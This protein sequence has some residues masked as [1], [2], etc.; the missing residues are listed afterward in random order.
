MTTTTV[1]LE[2]DTRSKAKPVVAHLPSDRDEHVA[3]CG[4][5]LTGRV[6]PKACDRCVVCQGLARHPN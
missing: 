6:A 2:H 5:P 3:L 4:T 1:E